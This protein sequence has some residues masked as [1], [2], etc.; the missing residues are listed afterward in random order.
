MTHR[1][2]LAL[3]LALTLALAACGETPEP[4]LAALRAVVE[5]EAGGSVVLRDI[6]R[7]HGQRYTL[8]YARDGDER[9]ASFRYVDKSWQLTDEHDAKMRLRYF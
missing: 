6:R 8:V 2:S 9:R 1:P 3:A 4:D 5:A 7:D